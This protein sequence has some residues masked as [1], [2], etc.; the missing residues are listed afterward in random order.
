[1]VTK[2]KQTQSQYDLQEE[3]EKA[4]YGTV[5]KAF[6]PATKRIYAAKKLGKAY[7][8]AELSI[9]QKVTYISRSE[10]ILWLVTYEYDSRIILWRL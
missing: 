8:P 4:A 1:L 7:L 2:G 10:I 9:L 5:F 6:D 3:I